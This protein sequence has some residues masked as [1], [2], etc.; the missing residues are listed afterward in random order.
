MKKAWNILY[1]AFTWIMM[2]VAVVVMI[3]TIISV[4]TVNRNNR[5]IFGHPART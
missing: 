2:L 4:T 1:T 5:Q 3:F